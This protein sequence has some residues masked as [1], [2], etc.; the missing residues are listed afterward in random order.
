MPDS[1]AI[2]IAE[3]EMDT[4]CQARAEIQPDVVNDYAALYK[5]EAELPPIEVFE[6]SGKAYVVDGFHRVPA[7]AKAG[8]AFL[9]CVTVG[10]GTID[11]AA[12]YATGVNQGH[13]IRRTNADKRR[14]IRLALESPIGQ[15]QSNRTIAEHVGVHHELVG[16]VRSE[17]EANWRKPPVETRVGKDGKRRSVAKTDRPRPSESE[18]PPESDASNEVEK[19]EGLVIPDRGFKAAAAAVQ[20][21]RREVKAAIGEV[22]AVDTPLSEVWRDLDNRIE[23]KCPQ[24]NGKGCKWCNSQ[25][26]TTKTDARHAKHMIKSLERGRRARGVA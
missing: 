3:L 12:W 14:A 13:G 23:I 20:R 24:C 6:V 5:A 11:E 19:P 25:G 7:A 16:K 22:Q 17:V 21:A 2:A 26:W 18:E 1:R 10:K 8:R 4:R 9:R 15:E